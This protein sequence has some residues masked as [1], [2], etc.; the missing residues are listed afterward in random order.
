ME[1][2]ENEIYVC[3]CK[4]NTDSLCA[5]NCEGQK[6]VKPSAHIEVLVATLLQKF[7]VDQLRELQLIFPSQ[8]ELKTIFPVDLSNRYYEVNPDSIWQGD[9]E[10]EFVRQVDFI[11]RG[12]TKIIAD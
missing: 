12:D 11:S 1:E 2:K 10:R 6:I 3:L 7:E 5:F 9:L 4:S 8:A